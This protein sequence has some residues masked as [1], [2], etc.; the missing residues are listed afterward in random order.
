[1]KIIIQKYCFFV[2]VILTV[3]ACE[4][5]NLETQDFIS[6]E[7]TNLEILSINEVKLTGKIKD[8]QIGQISD[9]GFL[10]TSESTIPTF[11]NN[12]GIQ[13]LGLKD[14]G[15]T[16]DFF[17]DLDN[18]DPSSSYIFVAFAVLNNTTYYSESMTWNSGNGM[19]F[20]D[21]I[22]YENGR[23]I[24]VYGHINGTTAGFIGTQHGFCWSAQNEFPNLDDNFIDLGVQR[25]DQSFLATIGGLNHEEPIYFRAFSVLRHPTTF[26]LDTLYGEVIFFNGDLWDIWIE[27]DSFPN[28][29][30]G[31]TQTPVGFSTMGNAYYYTGNQFENFWEYDSSAD[32]WSQKRNFDVQANPVGFSIDNKIYLGTGYNWD[33]GAPLANFWEY[34]PQADVWTQKADYAGEGF[35]SRP[36]AFSIGDKGY[37]GSGIDNIEFNYVTDFWGYNPESN[38]WS[39]KADFGGEGRTDAVSFSTAEKGYV[40]LGFNQVSGSLN[41]FWEFDPQTEAWTQ[42]ADFGG[43]RRSKATGFTINDKAY[44]GMGSNFESGDLNDFWEYNTNENAWTQLSNI[45]T[46]NTS[47]FSSFTSNERGFVG[48]F[49]FWEYIAR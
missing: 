10:W 9:H 34:D 18:F 16:P 28:L 25:S 1:M 48:N 4:K 30:S 49:N 11:I 42:L 31:F 39:R 47:L 7:L 8:L 46:T 36:F 13:S 19:V 45:P 44:V 32:R 23:N 3:F 26:K 33:T 43:A 37:M 22:R 38:V 40:G 17:A 27:R 5:W 24:E 15:D 29:G 2:L 41:D 6:V 21:S 12:E 35:T 20:T 14:K